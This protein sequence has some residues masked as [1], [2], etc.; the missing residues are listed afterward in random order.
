MMKWLPDLLFGKRR[1]AP[2]AKPSPEH[3]ALVRVTER[4]TRNGNP[5]D[6]K[7]PVPLLALEECFDGNREMGSIGCN[8]L[9]APTP[10]Q[11]YDLLASLRERED[12]SDIR[13][14]IT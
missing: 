14:Q 4:A 1:S 5:E 7:G 13:V 6:R 9:S 11:F 10:G 2:A 3:A 8:L 12:G